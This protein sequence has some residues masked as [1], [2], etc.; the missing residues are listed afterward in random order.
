[1]AR[2]VYSAPVADCLV[3]LELASYIIFMHRKFYDRKRLLVCSSPFHLAGIDER[4]A[5]TSGTSDILDG[6]RHPP[7]F[8]APALYPN[9]IREYTC[10]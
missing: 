6:G 9:H 4:I 8:C 2:F 5:E 1:M 7:T 10:E 3:A